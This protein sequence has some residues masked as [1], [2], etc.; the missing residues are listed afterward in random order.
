M[1]EEY[2]F[3]RKT[4]IFFYYTFNF[5]NKNY[6]L[7]KYYLNID[8]ELIVYNHFCLN[9]KFPQEIE[10]DNIMCYDFSRRY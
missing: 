5:E 8:Y 3:V 2:N 10:I 1:Y 6:E 7:K 9:Q 4:S